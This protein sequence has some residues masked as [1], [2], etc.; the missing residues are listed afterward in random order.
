[1]KTMFHKNAPILMARMPH[2][3]WDHHHRPHLAK[4]VQ[5]TT[6]GRNSG[7]VS[8][9]TLA[10]RLLRSAVIFHRHYSYR[11]HAGPSSM[12]RCPVQHFVPRSRVSSWSQRGPREHDQP[13]WHS[14]SKLPDDRIPIIQWSGAVLHNRCRLAHRS[15]WPPTVHTGSCSEDSSIMRTAA[16]ISRAT[17]I[18]HIAP[19][20][21]SLRQ[22]RGMSS[23]RKSPKDS[24]T[25]YQSS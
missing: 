11:R 21:G 25:G 17:P 10:C 9:A 8:C 2:D 23:H 15:R 1:M 4:W 13:E 3:P 14:C 7:L 19:G 12:R 6:A 24:I 5:T 20:E 22:S 18:T 16:M